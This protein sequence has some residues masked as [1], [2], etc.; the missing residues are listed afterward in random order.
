M[1]SDNQYKNKPFLNAYM[2]ASAIGAARGLIGLPLEHPFDLVKTKMQAEAA[3]KNVSAMQV[4]KDT[5][6]NSGVRG[7]YAGA[8]PNGF[9]MVSKEVYRCPLLSFFPT[10]YKQTVFAGSDD[11]KI[12]QKGL[13]GLSIATIEVFAITPLERFKVWMMTKEDKNKS[14]KD[15]L[16]NSGNPVKFAFQSWNIIYPRLIVTW[17]V[18]LMA[19]ETFKSAARTY[20]KSDKLSYSTL[21]GIGVAVG[22]VNLVASLPFDMVET[23]VQKDNPW[24]NQGAYKTMKAVH[25]AYGLSALYTGWRVRLSKQIL[26]SIINVNLLDVLD[27]NVKQAIEIE[28]VIN[29]PAPRI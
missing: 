20:Y 16:M 29:R 8:V 3:P 25:T 15:A 18:F 9:R 24:K 26:Q 2:N 21:A 4:V 17:A 10:F 27:R 13:T 22:T 14:L 5:Y 7:F 11:Y 28:P 6:K 1:K 12:L 23:L 19:D